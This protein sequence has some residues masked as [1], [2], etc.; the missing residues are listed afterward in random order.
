M[1]EPL[2]PMPASI[3]GEF[4][5]LW[6]AYDA[7]GRAAKGAGPLDA[8]SCRLP[9][10]ALAIGAGLEGA[11]HSHVRCAL[12]EGIAAEELEHVALL[13]VT[14]LGWP[15]AMRALSWVRD[16]TRA[17]VPPAG[18]RARRLAGR[19]RPT[20]RTGCGPEPSCGRPRARRQAARP[21]TAYGAG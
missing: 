12:D 8:R 7:L 17:E 9:H 21:A 16:L 15:G 18:D 4:P 20:V 11:T 1:A 3:A 5:E 10:L 6:R 13:A 19:P 2:P 14:T